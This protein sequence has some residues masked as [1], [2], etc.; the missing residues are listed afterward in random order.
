MLYLCIYMTDMT[1]LI[2]VVLF[3]FILHLLSIVMVM[4]NTKKIELINIT[5]SCLSNA[6]SVK[7]FCLPTELWLIHPILIWSRPSLYTQTMTKIL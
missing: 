6:F 3:H 5:E 4:I 7:N 1:S 2:F